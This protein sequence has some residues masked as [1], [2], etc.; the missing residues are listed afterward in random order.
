MT[1][2]VTVRGESTRISG[3]TLW[4]LLAGALAIPL[5]TLALPLADPD[6]PW[7]ILVG[8][9]LWQTWE[10]VGPAPRPGLL[11]G[12]YVYHQWLPQLAAAGA[13]AVW[14]LPGV[15]LLAHVGRVAV[16][17]AVYRLG[18]SH[19]SPAAACIT[20]ALSVV[21]LA[22]A[23]TARPQLAA[24]LLLAGSVYGWRA[25]ARDGR[26]R[27]WLVLVSWVWACSHGTWVVGLAVG[28]LAVA[29]RWWVDRP[30]VPRGP[31][32]VLA[33]SGLAGLA[34][35]LGLTLVS[36]VESIRE[37]AWFADEW[38]APTLADPPFIAFLLMVAGVVLGWAGHRRRPPLFDTLSVLLSV[39]M[40]V[41]SYRG[42]ALGAVIIGPVLAGA[43][44]SH[45]GSGPHP[46]PAII[47]RSRLGRAESARLALPI[48]LSV[49]LAASVAPVSA[50]TPGN[51]HDAFSG[52]LRALPVGSVVLNDVAL[53]GWLLWSYP[54][55]VP[56]VD[57]R[58]EAYGSDYLR[59]VVAAYHVQPG[60]EV[61]V[62]RT[63]ARAAVLKSDSPLATALVSTRGW[64]RVGVDGGFV[65]LLA[66]TG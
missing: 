64:T 10:F 49:V 53:G 61:L 21:A 50:A 23:F 37:V 29:A 19:G 39:G 26:T 13:Y 54:N 12:D 3:S 56:V 2:A 6:T 4:A 30:T 25:T 38:R 46:R 41:S 35:P 59:T 17:A 62:E 24:L 22:G 20:V 57:T 8:Q 47:A 14:G 18:R 28:G 63:A 42:V 52:S 33:A 32:L 16:L 1:D 36:A 11:S 60:W 55:V 65:L 27:W 40:A 48:I 9:R 66:P 15:A 44:T 51:A 34:T 45:R 31:A 58:L 43:L 5:A 7:H